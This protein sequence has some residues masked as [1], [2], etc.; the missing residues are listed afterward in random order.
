M[1]QGNTAVL[2]T[3]TVEEAIACRSVLARGA[4][5]KSPQRL[6]IEALEAGQAI[7]LDHKGF[8]HLAR[9]GCFSLGAIRL[10]NPGHRYRSWHDGDN[11][12]VVTC[13][14]RVSE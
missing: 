6:A 12:I 9:G 11:N 1:T 10:A 13:E 4:G 2:K 3:M 8:K 14:E 5:H 7:V